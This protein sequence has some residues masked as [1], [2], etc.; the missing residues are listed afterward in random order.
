MFVKPHEPITFGPPS[1]HNAHREFLDLGQTK[2]SAPSNRHVTWKA[3][4]HTREYQKINTFISMST[5]PPKTKLYRH[6]KHNSITLKL[7]STYKARPGAV[8]HASLYHPSTYQPHRVP[9]IVR[10][11]ILSTV[12]NFSACRAASALKRRRSRTRCVR[13]TFGKC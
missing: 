13:C 5:P 1:S 8:Q 4:H 3:Q 12:I 9:C 6:T 11:Y 10:V 7:Y 2:K